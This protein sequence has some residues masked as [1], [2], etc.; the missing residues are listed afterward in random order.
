[1]PG[2]R[3]DEKGLHFEGFHYFVKDA[4]EGMIRIGLVNYVKDG[5]DIT[6]TVDIITDA[7]PDLIEMLQ[8]FANREKNNN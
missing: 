2:Y 4:D 8:Y 5:E 7:L 6:E 1:M 3:T